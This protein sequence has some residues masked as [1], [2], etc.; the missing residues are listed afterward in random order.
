MQILACSDSGGDLTSSIAGDYIY[1][2]SGG[3]FATSDQLLRRE[4]IC[5]V[6]QIRL[7]DFGSGV[8]VRLYATDPQG[9]MAPTAMFTA[10]NQAGA[11]VDSGM[12]IVDDPVEIFEVADLTSTRFGTLVVDFFAGAGAMSAEY[13]AFGRFSVAVNATCVEPSH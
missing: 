1:L 3:N 5:E 13:S 11:E 8:R 10:Y 12:L 6:L 4:D 2:D 7:Q 9:A